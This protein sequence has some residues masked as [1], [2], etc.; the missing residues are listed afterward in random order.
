MPAAPASRFRRNKAAERDGRFRRPPLAR[1]RFGQA[2]G[3]SK[4]PEPDAGRR[5]FPGLQNASGGPGAV[6]GRAGGRKRPQ[7]PQRPS[8]A[9]RPENP[10]GEA[11]ASRRARPHDFFS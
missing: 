4:T 6:M 11:E 3:R 8:R 2:A 10:Q 7:G 5:P 9:K 1:R